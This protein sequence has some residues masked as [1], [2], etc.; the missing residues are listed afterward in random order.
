MGAYLCNKDCCCA[1]NAGEESEESEELLDDKEKKQKIKASLHA[2]GDREI[3]DYSESEFQKIKKDEKEQ[4]ELLAK[5]SM[6]HFQNGSSEASEGT[7][8]TGTE[9]T[10]ATSRSSS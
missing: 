7:Y 6:S 1:T 3:S 5:D 8:S 4:I 9:S 10:A 2:I